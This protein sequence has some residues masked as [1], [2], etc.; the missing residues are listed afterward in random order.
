MTPRAC[1]R[2]C[3]AAVLPE[4]RPS[5]FL[6]VLVL[7]DNSSHARHTNGSSGFRGISLSRT[8]SE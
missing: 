7:G 2:A 3:A 8:H 6:V 4:R 1:V 5:V